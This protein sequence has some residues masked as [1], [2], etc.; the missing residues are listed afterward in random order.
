V[1]HDLPAANYDEP[2]VPEFVLPDPLQLE[3]GD[4][5]LSGQDF[6]SRR[7]PELLEA[8]RKQVYGN[9]QAE[10]TVTSRWQ[11]ELQPVYGGLGARGEL[12]VELTSP[13][14]SA[15]AID[16]L[17]HVPR[18]PQPS[19]A[20][21]G[22]NLF[23]NQTLH[24]DPSISLAR[25]WLPENV[26][27]GLTGN[28][29]TEASRGMHSG[30]WPVEL[31][32]SRGYALV[33]AY[34]GDIDPDYDDG[35]RNGVH[36]L[37]PP[38]SDTRPDDGPGSLAAWAFGLSRI[39]DGIGSVP[40]IDS[41]RVAVVGHSRLGKAALWAAAQDQRF[42]VAISNESGCGGA[43]LSKRRFGERLIHINSRFPH[44]FCPAFKHFN[45]REHELPL[46][47]HLLLACIAPR[48]LYVASALGDQWADPRG[49]YLACV[50]ASPAYELFGLGGVS[51]TT[52]RSPRI[53]YHARPGR[54]DVTPRDF[55]H[56]LD[57]LDHLW[58]QPRLA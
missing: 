57:F 53:G 25:G 19:P 10:L 39:L 20:F 54:H 22:L 44:W 36:G 12:V 58:P 1:K 51:A 11:R 14:G 8:F 43:A 21:L 2:L 38:V 47:Q 35:F 37:L 13:T 7:R 15:L 41:S 42:A 31:V 3:S 50:A 56:Y 9:L 6:L 23:G 45:E 32:L 33:T 27:L 26:D 17:I 16:V 48:P 4:R 28:V 18:S 40:Q 46:D 24:P 34:A 5:V 29:A 30:R 49:E 52:A 55:W